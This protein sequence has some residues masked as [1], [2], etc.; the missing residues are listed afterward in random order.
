ME[1]RTEDA[2][3]RPRERRPSDFGIRRL[4]RRRGDWARTGSSRCRPPTKGCSSASVRYFGWVGTCCVST[5]NS[6]HQDGLITATRVAERDI[7]DTKGIYPFPRHV[8]ERRYALEVGR[9]VGRLRRVVCL[10]RREHRQSDRE[11]HALLV[12][13]HPHHGRTDFD[14]PHVDLLGSRT[15][16]GD[17][18]GKLWPPAGAAPPSAPLPVHGDHRLRR[19]R[20]VSRR[21]RGNPVDARRFPAGRPG[22]GV[23]GA[24]RTNR[25]GVARRTGARRT[26]KARRH[27]LPVP[28]R[29]NS[30]D[31]QSPSCSK[32]CNR[33][34][35][36][37]PPSRKVR[38]RSARPS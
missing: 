25:R 2:T 31:A 13:P 1:R 5:R 36:P 27:P 33:V 4:D 37:P 19:R 32:A 6:R 12:R 34:W 15:P 35:S 22:P 26:G 16:G 10:R 9:L 7:E 18:E 30:W 21:R 3:S 14:R 11:G 38:W 17:R 23:S 20:W 8:F 28:D 24:S 29:R